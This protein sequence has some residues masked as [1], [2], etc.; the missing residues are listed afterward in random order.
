MAYYFFRT[1]QKSDNLL[2]CVNEDIAN[3]KK[4]FEKKYDACIKRLEKAANLP[5]PE[6]V[7]E[8][9]RCLKWLAKDFFIPEDSLSKLGYGA[10]Y[11]EAGKKTP[12][13]ITVPIDVWKNERE[14]IL[15]NVNTMPAVTRLGN[16]SLFEKNLTGNTGGFFTEITLPELQKTVELCD[17]TYKGIMFQRIDERGHMQ[18][19][20]TIK[21]FRRHEKNRIALETRRVCKKLIQQIANGYR[22]YMYS[23]G[24]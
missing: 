22:I 16:K 6:Y 15:K 2:T 8:H 20:P 12:F 3:L 14:N 23:S 21:N 11:N 17:G 9:R 24:F 13:Y 18:Y 19:P 7:F 4:G 1:K 5:A 10:G